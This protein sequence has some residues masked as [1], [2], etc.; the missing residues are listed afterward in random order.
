L[1]RLS[2]LTAGESHGPCLTAIIEG[3][4]AGLRIDV[5]K[6]DR[7]LA[8]RQRGYG[9]GKR[10]EIEND[11]ARITS[12][13]I[14]NQTTGAP[15]TIQIDNKDWKNW[16]ER[17]ETSDLEPISVPRPGHADYAGMIKYG[18][19]DARPI[20]ERASARET[21][22]RVAI[23][24]LAK[25][26][27]ARFGMSIGSYVQQ[28]GSIKAEVP[29]LPFEK[30][31]SLAEDSD[32]SSPDLA[33][34]QQ[35]KSEID[36]A[37]ENGDTVGGI[38]TVAAT[39]VPVGLGSYTQWDNRLDGRLAQ[40]VMSIPA[41][42]GVEIGNG[43]SNATRSG[44]LVH[45]EILPDGNGGVKR[46][47]NRAGGIEGGI[48]NGSPIV[49]RA[50]VKPIPTLLNP[51]RSTDI[52]TGELSP[53]SYQRSDVC[54]VPAAAVVGESMVAWILAE[55]ILEKFGGDS[56]AEMKQ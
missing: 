48:T 4:P 51:L 33:S 39:G 43:F 18:V 6:I 56:I 11:H 12:G 30:L 3:L 9:R 47:T 40:A 5:A 14:N 31:W 28:I 24:S 42:K 45:D 46:V 34:E 17:F 49:L 26:L 29:D 21:A 1:R 19:R 54:V 20:L 32:V 23:G 36:R 13:V 41:V 50:A 7:E 52:T 2:F 38:F 8:R 15:V 35:M 55:A 25:Q 16:K 10:M 27:L 37:R 44:R 53:A 22:V